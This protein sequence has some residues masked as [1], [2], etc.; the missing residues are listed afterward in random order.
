VSDANDLIMGSSV[1]AAKFANIGDLVQGTIVKI[2]DK[3]QA[4]KFRTDGKLGD[5]ATWDDGQPIWQVRIDIQTDVRDPLIQNDDGI[6]GL[7]VRAG[8]ELRKVVQEAVR[9][10]G[11]KEILVG[12]FLGVQFI[13]EEPSGAAVDK[14]L[15]QAVYRP[16]NPGSSLLMDGPPQQRQAPTQGQQQPGFASGQVVAPGLQQQPVQAQNPIQQTYQ[17][18][19][20]IPQQQGYQPQQYQQPQQTAQQQLAQDQQRYGIPDPA[21]VSN[22]Q[23]GM[24]QPA[25]NPADDP[26]VQQLLHN[27]Q[28]Q[29]Q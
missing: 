28:Q 26:K 27:V 9:M 6:R 2:G 24:Q 21:Q 17:Q 11:S 3:V 15:Y 19:Q 4:R 8:S 22:G 5:L 7:Y 25:S 29:Q 13:G 10:S 12:G 20:Q 1:E 18:Q 14:K 23:L 16:P